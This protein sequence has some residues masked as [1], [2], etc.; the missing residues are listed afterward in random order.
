MFAAQSVRRRGGYLSYSLACTAM[1]Q[2]RYVAL[3]H[4]FRMCLKIVRAHS[5]FTCDACTVCKCASF[6]LEWKMHVL[7]VNSSTRRDP[8]DGYAERQLPQLLSS[9]RRSG[10]FQPKINLSTFFSV[11]L[12]SRL[13]FGHACDTIEIIPTRVHD[14]MRLRIRIRSPMTPYPLFRS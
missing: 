4:G 12:L 6:F 1:E 8:E 10:T 14:V 5:R 13:E 3:K 11:G 2:L 7:H 9:H